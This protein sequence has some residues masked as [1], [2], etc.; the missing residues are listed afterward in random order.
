MFLSRYFSYY[1]FTIK[2]RISSCKTH[3]PVT[4]VHNRKRVIRAVRS[5]NG[6]SNT[7][8]LYPLEVSIVTTPN[9][10]GARSSVM[11]AIQ[12][13]V[14]SVLRKHDLLRKRVFSI[15]I[16]MVLFRDPADT[17]AHLRANA[18][19]LYVRGRGMLEQ[20]CPTS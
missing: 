8:L 12:C 6:D 17:V 20:G 2:W 10:M 14:D 3:P 4:R 9:R 7:R 19:R 16:I 15:M 1:E 5:C 13:C 11:A 18:T